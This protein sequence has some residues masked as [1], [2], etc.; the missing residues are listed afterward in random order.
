[1]R[2]GAESV[3]TPLNFAQDLA[4]DLSH[5]PLPPEFHGQLGEI[6]VPCAGTYVSA[7]TTA[8]VNPHGD[9]GTAAHCDR[10]QMA[11]ISV[12]VARECAN[13]ANDDGTTNWEAQDAVSASM[14][15]DGEMLRDWAEKIRADAWYVQGVVTVTYTITGAMQMVILSFT[16]PVP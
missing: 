10:I 13:V 11:D 1:M 4:A 3:V 14:D 8:E 15:A 5:L 6:V 9:L 16:T 2:S 7:L 12:V